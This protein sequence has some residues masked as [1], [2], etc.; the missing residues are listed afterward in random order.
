MTTAYRL[1]SK[2]VATYGTY[3]GRMLK[4]ETKM[5]QSELDLQQVFRIQV[6]NMAPNLLDK[7]E[8]K[9]KKAYTS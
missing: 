8:K 3:V 1:I 4:V 2:V 7:S 5:Y 6:T 9:R